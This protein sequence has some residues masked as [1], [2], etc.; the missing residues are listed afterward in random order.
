MD[1]KESSFSLCLSLSFFFFFSKPFALWVD[2]RKLRWH[3]FTCSDSPISRLSRRKVVNV[4]CVFVTQPWP[5]SSR[6][7]VP[8][9]AYSSGS[10]RAELIFELLHTDKNL[11]SKTG[12]KI[13]TRQW[14]M[15]CH[16]SK[17]CGQVPRKRVS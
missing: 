16:Y 2:S 15:G 13:E 8:A 5:C 17:N 14:S 4:A 11:L 10:M 1:F 9:S 3:Q 12:L 6:P 7:S